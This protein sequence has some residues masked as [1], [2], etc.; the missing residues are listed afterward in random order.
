MDRDLALVHRLGSPWRVQPGHTH[1]HADHI[2][3]ALKHT[4]GTGLRRRHST[5]CSARTSASRKVCRSRWPLSLQPLQQCRATRMAISPTCLARP[6]VHGRC[7]VDRR[8]GRIGSF[9]M[10]IDAL[11]K[12]VGKLFALQP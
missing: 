11:F 3:A 4:V 9:K 10:A 12:S 1:I 7:A 2:S 5:G 6:A 8:C